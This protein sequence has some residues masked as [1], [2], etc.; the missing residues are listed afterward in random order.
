MELS[1]TVR[2]PAIAMLVI[3]SHARH[4]GQTSSGIAR[5]L[6]HTAS[7]AIA[8]SAALRVTI[9]GWRQLIGDEQ[10]LLNCGFGTLTVSEAL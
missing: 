4:D 8:P 7:V 3:L 2:L 10:L 6:N 1:L 9:S 5:V